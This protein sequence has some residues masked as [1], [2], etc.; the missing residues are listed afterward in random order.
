MSMMLSAGKNIKKKLFIIAW[1]SYM[2]SFQ[3]FIKKF[4]EIL[5]AVSKR[6]EN[7]AS[8]KVDLENSL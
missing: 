7:Q 5:P 2:H 1:V 8:E 3:N 4:L 6:N